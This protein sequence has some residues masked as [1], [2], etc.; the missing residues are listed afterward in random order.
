MV[1][2]ALRGLLLAVGAPLGLIPFLWL[3]AS[4]L[5][6][7]TARVALLYS[8]VGTAV[9][10]AG[11]GAFTGRLMDLQRDAALRDG[12]TG[13]Y[14]RRFMRETLPRLQAAIARTDA[15]LCVIMLDLDHFKA[16]NDTHG[17]LIGDQTLRAVAEVLEGESRSTDVVARYGGEEFA[18]LCP[19][20]D[21]AMGEQVAE[22][23]REAIESLDG[24][25]LGFPGPQTVSLGLAIQSPSYAASPE[26]I[27][28]DADAALY[29]AKHAG[30]NCVRASVDGS[31]V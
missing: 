16:V 28:D 8:G 13:L 11:V 25:A 7:T 14:N 21:L 1:K 12:L 19:R 27:I 3:F 20:T 2:W 9:V 6:S 30:R 31:E 10:F 5:S 29:R 15:P 4:D 23:L 26:Q 17:H 24:Q 18:V 22:R